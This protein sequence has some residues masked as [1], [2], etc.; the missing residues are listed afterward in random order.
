MMTEQ[1]PDKVKIFASVMAYAP[2][3]VLRVG[4]AYLRLKRRVRKTSRSFEKGLLARG[5]MPE[6]A[7]RLTLSYE[8]DFRTRTLFR[9]LTGGTFPRGGAW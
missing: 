4:V 7:R 6:T 3:L 8:G 5:M 9:R 2:L 1:E